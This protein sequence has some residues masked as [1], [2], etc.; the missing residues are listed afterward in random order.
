VVNPLVRRRNGA[1]D[2]LEWAGRSPGSVPWEQTETDAALTEWE[3]ADGA[4]TVRLRERPDGGFVVRADR[5]RQAPEGSAYERAR[6]DDRE[7][8]EE[9]AA[10]FRERYD[11]Q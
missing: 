6:A 9:L 11:T 4:A 1:T 3:R 10:T 7:T 5:L 8:A 2:A